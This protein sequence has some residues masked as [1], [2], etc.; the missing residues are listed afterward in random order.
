MRSFRVNGDLQALARDK[1]LL[2]LT[3]QALKECIRC[4]N[5]SGTMY[6]FRWIHSLLLVIFF[7][8]LFQMKS[9]E[10][11]IKG[12]ILDVKEEI[13]DLEKE[14]RKIFTQRQISTPA[15]D[16]LSVLTRK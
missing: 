12:P 14:F 8:K 11:G 5:T 16:A 13:M 7:R 6:F 15:L 2:K 9:A 4:F 1:A 10:I 3:I